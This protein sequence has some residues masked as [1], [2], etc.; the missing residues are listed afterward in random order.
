MNKGTILADLLEYTQQLI[1]KGGS[2]SAHKLQAI[3]QGSSPVKNETQPNKPNYT[4]LIIGGVLVVSL[5]LVVGY[6]VGKR[7]KEN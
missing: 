3:I 6:F 2:S 1:K 7:R 5:A 4:P